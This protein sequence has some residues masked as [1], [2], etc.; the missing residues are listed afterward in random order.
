VII[1]G[2]LYTKSELIFSENHTG[3]SIVDPSNGLPYMIKD[4]LVP[5]KP[6]TVVDMYDLRQASKDV[7]KIVS[8]YLTLKLPQPPRG[9]VMAIPTKYHVYSPFMNTLITDIRS[10]TLNLPTRIGGFSKQEIIDLCKNYEYILKFDPI[11]SPYVQDERFVAVDPHGY[12]TVVSVSANAY[13]FLNKVV[14]I[15]CDG[16]IVLSPFLKTA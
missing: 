5:V 12:P 15:Y 14:E 10:G 16:R 11:K 8:D 7:D 6:Y 9:D 2:K 4:M 1:G 13:R 3:I